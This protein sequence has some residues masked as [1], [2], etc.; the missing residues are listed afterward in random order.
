MIA[1]LFLFEPSR[2]VWG[3]AKPNVPPHVDVHTHHAANRSGASLG[4][5]LL[6]ILCQHVN[7][8]KKNYE[9]VAMHISKAVNGLEPLKRSGDSIQTS[10]NKIA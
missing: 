1:S 7:G 4:K 10:N 3:C 5:T 6:T 8:G 9:S 2:L